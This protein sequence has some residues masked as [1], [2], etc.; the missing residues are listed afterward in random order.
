LQT[1]PL[2]VAPHC[3]PAGKSQNSPLGQGLIPR[4]P[5]AFPEPPACTGT[6]VATAV[7]VGVAVGREMGVAVAVGAAVG[8]AVGVAVGVAVAVA[9]GSAVGVAV[10][11]PPGAP[12]SGGGLVTTTQLVKR[13]PR[14]MAGRRG[15][16]PLPYRLAFSGS[17]F[18]VPRASTPLA[19][20]G[21]RETQSRRGAKGA[22][23][24]CPSSLA[25]ARDRFPRRRPCAAGPREA[26]SGAPPAHPR[27]SPRIAGSAPPPGA[28]PPPAPA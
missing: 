3:E 13:R 15:L 1:P 5:Q 7:A 25:Q 27:R 8:M 12:W 22:T 2:S 17:R 9:V 6:D 4:L 21:R 26:E 28:P 14:R 20:G 10:G 11:S 24:G 19:R 23:G 18:F 16:T